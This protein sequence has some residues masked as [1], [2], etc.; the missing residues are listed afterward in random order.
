MSRLINYRIESVE[1]SAKFTP[2]NLDADDFYN[3]VQLASANAGVGKVLGARGQQLV[4]Q[5]TKVG[6]PVLTIPLAVPDQGPLGFDTKSRV[7]EVNLLAYRK[8]VSGALQSLYTL[9]ARA[10]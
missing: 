2:L 6:D 10:S 7:G 1:A 8:N 9:A 4:V 3:F 5:S